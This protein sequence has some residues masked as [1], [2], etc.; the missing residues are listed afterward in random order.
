MKTR[1]AIAF[2]S[3]LLTIARSSFSETPYLKPVDPSVSVA[4]VLTVGGS[5]PRTSDKSQSFRLIG[6][7]DGLGL[8]KEADGTV[9]LWVN[10][11]LEKTD[12]SQ[13]VPGT[14]LQTG[15]FVSL[16]QL[17]SDRPAPVSGDFAASTLFLGTQAWGRIPALFCSGNLSGAEVGFDRPIYFTGEEATGNQSGDGRGGMGFAFTGGNAYALPELGRYRKE[18]LVVVP[19]TGLKTLLFGLEDGPKGLNSELYLYIGEK[20]LSST[21]P[22]ERN[23]LTGGRLYVL[24]SATD[25]RNDETTFHKINSPL[26]G[27]WIPVDGA[28]GLTDDELDAKASAAGAFRFDRIEDGT[29]DR[30][31]NG[32][33]YFVTTGGGSANAK[34][35]L[36]KLTFNPKDPLASPMILEILIE[37]DAGDPIVSPDNIDMNA[38]GE[39]LILED[40]T[41]DNFWTYLKRNNSVW[42]YRPDGNSKPVR[43]AEAAAKGWEP[44]GVIDA[45]SVYGPGSWILDV[46]AH[47]RSSAAASAAAGLTGDAQLVEGGQILLLRTR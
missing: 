39:M 35:R 22:L 2:L 3:F 45:S 27:R 9:K 4:P 33:F 18:N 43:I 26:V 28:S 32:V 30:R 15:A 14:P 34:G 10:H 5:V 8:L 12:V 44:T 7:T 19:G 13:P 16:F 20:K 24:G 38:D 42:L 46:Q 21:D 31:R 40:F 37:G 11:E 17:A 36:Y 25:G 1:L 6:E 29:Y 47:T 23:G 41:L